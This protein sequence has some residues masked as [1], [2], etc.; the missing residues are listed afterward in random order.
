LPLLAAV[1]RQL[2]GLPLALEMAAARVPLMGLSAV[3]DA[4][5]ERFALLSRVRRD[6]PA[7][8]R[9]LHDALDWSYGLLAEQEQRLFRALGVFAGGFTLDLAVTLTADEHVGRWDI[10]DGLATLV[11]RS[12]V[13]VSGEDPPRYRMLETMRAFALEQL[14][15]PGAADERPSLVRRH[16]AAVLSLFV[17]HESD[18]LCLAEM[19][20]ARVAFL[21]A[22]DNDLATAAQLSARAAQTIGF[23]V[24]RQEVT[25]WMLSLEPAMRETRAQALTLQTQAHWWSMLAYVLNVRR[26]RAATPAAEKA[27]LLWRQLDSPDELQM[28]LV[29]WVRSIPEPG[30]A[31]DA[32]CAQ[33]QH[34]AAGSRGTPR[35]QLR[36][37]GAL[38]EA[39]RVRGDFEALLVCRERELLM[40]RELGWADMAQ[41]AES[42]VCAALIEL[43]RLDEAAERGRALLQR[44]DAGGSET[45]GNLPWVLN[46]LVE[47]LNRLGRYAEAQALV[48]R[49]IATDR[50]F[51]TTVAWHGILVLVAAQGRTA[52]AARLLG[53]AAQLWSAHGA[54][55]DTDEQG[56]LNEVRALIEARL[57]TEIATSL[58]AEGRLLDDEA[59]AALACGEPTDANPPARAPD[60]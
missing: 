49:S 58:A 48:P 28:A 55:P 46:V 40:A 16:A 4:L 5:A 34:S 12:L 14:A 7:R 38:A 1:C 32:A 59:A 53:Y 15:A 17:R 26:S 51:G 21:W 10:V 54:T 57:G 33:L 43:G 18:E 25:G 24:W 60:R 37:Q 13:V 36:V 30:P 50:R 31:L 23:S 42:N 45:N 20:N 22:R 29:H 8:H 47:A 27:V 44:I 11:E 3:H 2:D 6:S 35:V 19:E 41:A 52:A 9:T 56:R 39:A